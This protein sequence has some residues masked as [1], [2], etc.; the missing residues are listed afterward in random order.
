MINIQ[1]G[2]AAIPNTIPH[3]LLN[4]FQ[5]YN[6][7]DALNYKEADNW[8][9]ISA[10]TIAEKVSHVALG[11][12][13]LGINAGDKIAI[14]S[15]NR[16]EWSITDLAALSLRAVTVPL[17]PT[18]APDQIRYILEDCGA[19]VLFLSSKKI[20]KHAA[21]AIEGIEPL[22]HLI[23]FDND[24][25]PP[26][27]DQAMAYEDLEKKGAEI[28]A[29]DKYIYRNLLDEVE[30]QDL[31]TIIYTSGTTGEP[32]GVMLTHES[33]VS[34]VATISE[35]LPILPTDRSIAV[36]PLSHIF[37]RACFYVMAA[38]GVA[39]HYCASFDHLA[40]YLHEVQPTVMTAVP[41]LFEKV[42]HKIIRK[43]MT[44]GGWKT[45]LFAWALEVGQNYWDYKD[46][47]KAMPLMM[48]LKHKIADRLVFTKWR[49]AVGGKLR[50]FVSGGAPLSKKLSYA[51]WSA[52]IEILQGYGTTE[53]CIVAANRPHDTKAGSIGRPFEGIEVKIAE[54]DGEILVRGKNVMKGYYNRPDLTAEVLTEDGWYK[55]GDIGYIDTKSEHIFITDRKK[56]LF[57]L[58]N[59]KYIAPQQLESL[60]KQSQFVSQAVVVGSGRKQTS[61]LI[62]PDFEAL[63]NELDERGINSKRTREE[64]CSDAE[65]VKIVQRDVAEIMR[66]RTDYER[67][68][69][70]ALLPHEFSIDKG[71]MTPTLKIKRAVIDEKYED[72]IDKLSGG[73]D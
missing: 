17:F 8:L 67:V 37:E 25:V 64:L 5:K 14:I 34:N 61:A 4:A 19:R 1:N 70:V 39:I 55:T 41:R 15:E 23:F 9:R 11:L 2:S 48:R 42:Y 18:A 68:K 13:N 72:L 62:V 58:S 28:I 27:V 53:C 20:F 52:G 49:E 3:F 54:T 43:G 57:K 7:P 65:V 22:E 40:E 50:F 47:G 32:K 60:V 21:P 59:G 31:A 10:E 63:K 26:D 38:N 73:M 29:K 30:P 66:E 24:A 44:A 69:K 45:K 51:F 56:D 36:L 6:K 16:P 46:K 35:G 33:F 71:E 12:R